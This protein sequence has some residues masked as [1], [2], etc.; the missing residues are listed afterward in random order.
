M[1][2]ITHIH[3]SAHSIEIWRGATYKIYRP[4]YRNECR[5]RDVARCDKRLRSRAV[6]N[7]TSDYFFGGE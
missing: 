6:H 1:T 3:M 5:L 2:K 7:T 4:I